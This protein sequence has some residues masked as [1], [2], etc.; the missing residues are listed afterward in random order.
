M[1]WVSSTKLW[2]SFLIVLSKSFSKD[3]S[4]NCL[5]KSLISSFEIKDPFIDIDNLV[6]TLIKY[7]D[8]NIYVMSFYNTVI[9]K[10]NIKNKTYKVGILNYVLNTTEKHFKYDFICILRPLLNDKIIEF[11]KKNN[12]ELF[13]YGNYNNNFKYD[14]PYYIVD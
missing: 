11:V 3:F 14:F 1:S 8:K 4:F 7:S 13:V 2:I 6:E 12:K 10:L 9:D 5:F